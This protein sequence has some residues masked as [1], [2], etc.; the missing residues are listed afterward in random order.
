MD[1]GATKAQPPRHFCSFQANLED[2]VGLENQH[3]R[4]RFTLADYFWRM[5][6]GSHFVGGL[7]VE[8]RRLY[9]FC[10]VCS[11]LSYAFTGGKRLF[12]LAPLADTDRRKKPGG[13]QPRKGP[14]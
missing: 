2:L 10:W 3:K 13:L 14:R 4:E 1:W 7:Q 11:A 9:M 6:S 5:Y 12:P 8:T